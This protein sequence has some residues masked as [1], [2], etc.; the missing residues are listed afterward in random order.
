RGEPR[1]SG[2]DNAVALEAIGVDQHGIAVGEGLPGDE[3]SS[4][5]DGQLR[6]DPGCVAGTKQTGLGLEEDRVEAPG[7][8]APEEPDALVGPKPFDRNS[9]LAQ[10]ALARVVPAVGAGEEPRDSRRHE[11]LRSGLA[12][13]LAPEVERA[14]RRAGVPVVGSVREADQPR[15]AP[16]RG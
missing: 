10:N 7:G 5:L 4:A 11:Q 3:T 1:A 9:L 15:L 16:G 12:L 2:P 8:E 6:G 14:A 13:E